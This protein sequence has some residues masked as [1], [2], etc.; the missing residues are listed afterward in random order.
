MIEHGSQTRASAQPAAKSRPLVSS[1]VAPPACGPWAQPGRAWPVTRIGSPLL[2]APAPACT[3]APACASAPGGPSCS[4]EAVERP[5]S[6]S[7]ASWPRPLGP[8]LISGCTVLVGR[9]ADKAKVPTQQHKHIHETD[10]TTTRYTATAQ[11][12]SWLGPNPLYPPPPP[13]MQTAPTLELMC[14]CLVVK[15]DKTTAPAVDRG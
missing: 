8:K 12:R 9:A 15:T 3:A 1:R 4:L 10:H 2:A 13:T 11:A 6:P 7:A 5:A 14:V